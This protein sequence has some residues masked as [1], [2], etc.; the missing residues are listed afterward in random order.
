MILFAAQPSTVNGTP[1][2]LVDRGVVKTVAIT[3]AFAEL[4]VDAVDG[5]TDGKAIAAALTRAGKRF[6]GARIAKPLESEFLHGQM[7]GA[8][9]ADWEAE[10]AKT[11]KP[12]SFSALYGPTLLK[13]RDT[14]FAERPLVEA[15]RVFQDREAVTPKVFASMTKA[16]KRRAFTI[17][18]AT[19]KAM[20]TTAKRA[21]ASQLARGADLRN[22]R[23]VL[24]RRLESAGWVPANASHVETIFRTNVMASYGGGR[25]KQMLQPDV[26]EARPYWQIVT[27]NDGPPR[28]R[29]THQ[30]V[31]LV[32]LRADDPFWRT[33][34]PPFGFNCRCR[35]RSLGEREG[36]ELVVSGSSIKNLPDPGFTS[37]IGPLL[38]A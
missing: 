28:Q 3:G 9:D 23:E 38:A 12:A 22:F 19:S 4:L 24:E 25:A 2:T 7:L 8:L 17:A 27:V 31:H 35:V 13:L 26:L 6:S 29:K 20:V 34:Y 21:L 33:C 32:V 1:E 37:G 15:I 11:I 18:N 5:K 14:R 36:A 10:N 30:A 16:A